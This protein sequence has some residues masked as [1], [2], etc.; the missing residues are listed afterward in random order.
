M[1]N[2]PVTG[3]FMV[4]TDFLYYK[5]G[6]YQHELGK[7]EGL[8]AIRIIGWGVENGVK[9]WLCANSWNEEWGDK[10]YFKFLRGVNA[11]DIEDSI[12][13]VLPKV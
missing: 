5:T 9:Y 2:G 12:A 4:Y 3:G 11:L 10:G 8:H 1:K 7:F 6:V 13:A